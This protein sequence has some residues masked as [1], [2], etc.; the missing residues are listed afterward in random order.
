MTP[1]QF[2]NIF[3]DTIMELE[4]L[5][6]FKGGIYANTKNRLHNFDHAAHI[7]QIT[8]L[9]ACRGMWRKQLV[10]LLDAI[11]NANDLHPLRDGNWTQ[12]RCDEV[13]NDLLVYLVLTKAIFYREYGW[14]PKST[15]ITTT[16]ITSF[17]TCGKLFKSNQEIH[18]HLSQQ[19]HSKVCKNCSY[20]YYEHGTRHGA[21]T[22]FE[23]KQ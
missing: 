10:T 23:E 12:E 16:D 19:T 18:M 20:R 13:I 7:D 11:D 1:E 6:A 14:T 5:V 3:Q 22:S 17:C 2:N 15:Q 4:R 8:P 21:C 9:E